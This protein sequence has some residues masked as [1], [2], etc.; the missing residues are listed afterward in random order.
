[1]GQVRDIM[2]KNVITID[3]DETA[4]NAA[5]QMKENDISFLVIIENGKP[6]GVVSERDFVQKLCINNQSSSDVK[7]SDIMSY[8]F[9]WVNPTTKIEDAI[10]K[11]L[12][13]NIRRL[14]V[15]DDEKL[16]GVITQT[17]LAS[18]LREKLMIDGTIKDIKK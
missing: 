16:V 6:V 10:Q 7:I 18:Y 5:N 3:I 14:L 1:M 11:M 13:N 8:K 4:N 17:D 15:L 2:E 9:R 12:N